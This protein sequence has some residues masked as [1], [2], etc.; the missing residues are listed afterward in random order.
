MNLLHSF[1]NIHDLDET[2]DAYKVRYAVRGVVLDADGN[3]GM[4]HA[5]ARGYY[6][7][8]GGTMEPGETKEEGLKREMKEELGCDVEIVEELG[9]IH[10]I[11][12]DFNHIHIVYSFLAKVIGEKGTQTL[13]DDEKDLGMEI[14]WV[15][16]STAIDLIEE[17]KKV[18]TE[19]TDSNERNLIIL[20][21]VEKFFR[22]GGKI[23]KNTS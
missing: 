1:G 21:E 9:E 17:S 20:N 8:P 14:Y 16:L 18:A 11:Y 3:I 13:Q 10:H 7:V 12:K 19:H 5:T 15:P 4:I 6:E 22:A 2:K 23:A